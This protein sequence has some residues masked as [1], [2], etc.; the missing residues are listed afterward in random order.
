MDKGC[1]MDEKQQA[2]RK[3]EI[4]KY[5]DGGSVIVSDN[6][7]VEEP[8]EVRLDGYPVAVLMRTPGADTALVSGFLVTEGI[9]KSLAQIRKM[10]QDGNRILVFLND[11][12]RVDVGKF[13]RNMYAGSS[14]GI[15]GKATL[16]AIFSEFPALEAARVPVSTALLD[17]PGKLLEYQENFSTTGGLHAAGLFCFGG[18]LLLLHEDIGRHNA[19]DK[20]VGSALREGISVA[21]SWLLV[22]GRV[23]FE[24]MQK[25]LAIGI[26]CVAAISAP[27]SLAIDFAKSS[28]QTLIGF[29]RPPGYNRYT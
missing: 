18:E 20:V 26:P 7:V 28:G 22:S 19:V 2:V 5:S 10:E 13:S 16:E 9:L 17:A 27:S 11:G 3:V 1:A 8:L 4:K 6:V 15:C 25:A 21:D 24:I 29:L 23:S 14:C 12:E